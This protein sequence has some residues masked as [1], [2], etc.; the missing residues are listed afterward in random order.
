M[1]P[2][3]FFWMYGSFCR[4]RDWASGFSES[5]K[6]YNVVINILWEQM[7][8]KDNGYRHT[9]GLDKMAIC[10]TVICTT[11]YEGENF[12]NFY[13]TTI[14]KRRSNTLLLAHKFTARLNKSANINPC[15]YSRQIRI[16][17]FIQNRAIRI[18]LTLMSLIVIERLCY[19]Q[20]DE[21]SEIIS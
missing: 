14:A 15:K 21:I 10:W 3:I 6:W 13:D 8:L 9:G 20:R 2:N 7:M 1:N 12:K 19:S 17:V 11:L 18:V 5:W 4:L 16:S